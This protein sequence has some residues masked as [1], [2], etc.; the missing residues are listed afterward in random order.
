MTARYYALVA[1]GVPGVAGLAHLYKDDSVCTLL[2]CEAATR[3][4]ST[5][6]SLP[7]HNM[8]QGIAGLLKL[9]FDA[10]SHACHAKNW[11]SAGINL[12]ICL[13]QGLAQ[14]FVE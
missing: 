5:Q 1:G 6:L 12:L 14:D 13:A 7:N 2:S 10:V 3:K 4:Q 11:I 9:S 8:Q